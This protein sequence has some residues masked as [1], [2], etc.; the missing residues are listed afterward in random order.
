MRDPFL[1]PTTTITAALALGCD[2]SSRLTALPDSPGPLL[3]VQR[4]T[5]E[6]VF[7]VGFTDFLPPGPGA[8]GG[9]V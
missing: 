8:W 4:S 2:G 9:R 1:L 7:S 6:F 3:S 5:E